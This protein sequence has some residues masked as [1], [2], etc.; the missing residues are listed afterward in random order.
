M[1]RIAVVGISGS[2]KSTFANKLGEKL[3]IPSI[4]LDKYFWTKDWTERYSRADFQKVA[5]DFAKAD[6]WIIDGNY[7]SSIDMRFE[8]ADTIIFLDYPKYKCIWRSFIRG[9]NKSQ[10][11]DKT[12]GAKEKFS[13]YLLKYN[14]LYPTNEMRERV[15]KYINSKQVFVVKN[16]KEK[17]C[18]LDLITENHI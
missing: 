4:H 3:S 1:K 16:D 5:E 18:L 11:F 7:R 6:T 14:L 15:Q 12:E 17:W 2:G 8:R 13:L 9:F 10:P